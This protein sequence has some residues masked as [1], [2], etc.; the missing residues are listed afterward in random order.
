MYKSI[1]AGGVAGV[2]E[3]T[4]MY[5][6]DVMKTRAQ[7]SAEP[8][9]MLQTSKMVLKE[10]G[11]M[12]FYR[13]I[14]IPILAE[15]P[16]RAWKF[17]SKD[18][19]SKNVTPN[20]AIAGALAGSSEAIVNCPF[21]TIKVNLQANPNLEGSASA[22]YRMLVKEGGHMSLYRGFEAQAYRNCLWN[23]M[24]FGIIGHFPPPEGA[25]K[26]TTL[27][28]KFSAGTMGSMMG[29]VANTPFDVAKSRMQF[30]SGKACI[31][32]IMDIYAEGGAKA[33]YKGLGPRLVRLGP[34]GGIMIVAYDQMMAFLG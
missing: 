26:K 5:P 9:S 3:I 4:C 14:S 17:G 7:L 20:A 13:G 2:A 25:D 33:L 8:L 32:T 28:H 6:T 27:L 34:G 22:C 31:P 15:A 18:F 29:T 23:G 1:L 30:G 21:E 10:A 11:V 24:Y 19:F 12:G 16:K